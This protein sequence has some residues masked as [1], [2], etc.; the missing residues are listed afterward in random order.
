MA[1]CE[2]ISVPGPDRT[3]TVRHHR[4]AGS[5]SGEK[6]PALVFFHGGGLVTGDLDTHDVLCRELSNGAGCAVFLVCA[7]GRAHSLGGESPLLTR[8]G[9]ELAE[10]QG[11]PGRLGI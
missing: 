11:C 7:P 1:L 3:I 9:E 4:P 6:L 8:Q 10:R 5:A 2:G